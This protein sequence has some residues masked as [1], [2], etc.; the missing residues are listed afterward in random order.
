MNSTS[1]SRRGVRQAKIATV[2]PLLL[3]AVSIGCASMTGHMTGQTVEEVELRERY[4]AGEWI[5]AGGGTDPLGRVSPTV[6]SR[7]GLPV[8][9]IRRPYQNA[10][11][12][13]VISCNEVPPTIFLVMS[14]GPALRGGQARG[15]ARVKGWSGLHPITWVGLDGEAITTLAEKVK[16]ATASEFPDLR[17]ALHAG[18]SLTVSAP[19]TAGT[20]Y[21]SFDLEGLEIHEKE[22]PPAPDTAASS[23]GQHRKG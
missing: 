16:E 15:E 1:S 3:G 14:N 9:A 18:D 21:F 20:V 7:R 5:K 12:A 10:T 19:T 13:L 2:A 6:F 23:R 22:C 17:E 4:R 11:A 8:E